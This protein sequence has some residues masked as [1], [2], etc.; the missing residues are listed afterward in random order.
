M[1]IWQKLVDLFGGM[2]DCSLACA[3][4][5]GLPNQLKQL[6][7]AL[8]RMDILTIDKLPTQTWSVI[9]DD[10]KKVTSAVTTLQTQTETEEFFPMSP[11]SK[12]NMCNGPNHIT[13]D[14]LS[15]QIKSKTWEWEPHRAMCCFYC[16]DV[17]HI[18]QNC[19]GNELME[20]TLVS[21][22]FLWM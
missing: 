7:Y 13:R 3:I 11:C 8:S 15:H 22:S 12:N 16:Q 17:S 1:C 14:C 18:F 20:K 9:K 21:I 10:V 4:M 19:L 6:F 5:A 2:T